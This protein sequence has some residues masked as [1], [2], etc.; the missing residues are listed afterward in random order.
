MARICTYSGSYMYTYMYML[1]M[2]MYTMVTYGQLLIDL[3]SR[4]VS[5]TSR[6]CGWDHT[7]E[8]ILPGGTPISGGFVHF[9]MYMYMNVLVAG[10]MHQALISHLISGARVIIE[11]YHCKLTHTHEMPRYPLPM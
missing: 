8:T 2:Y 5:Y 11:G 3:I 10:I 6:V 7:H 1:Y 9:S 4:L